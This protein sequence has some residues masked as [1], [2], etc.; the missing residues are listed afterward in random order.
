MAATPRRCRALCTP[1]PTALPTAISL[2][3][4]TLCRPREGSGGGA[5]ALPLPPR[6]R[7]GA[8]LAWAFSCAAAPAGLRGCGNRAEPLGLPSSGGAAATAAAALA[9]REK[10]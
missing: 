1:S 6:S 7:S 4:H 8:P 10:V 3:D 2:R 9:V 5:P